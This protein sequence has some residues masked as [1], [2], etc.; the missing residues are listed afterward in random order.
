MD[1]KGI[2]FRSGKRCACRAAIGRRGRPSKD[3][4]VEVI[5]APFGRLTEMN[6]VVGCLLVHGLFIWRKW[7]V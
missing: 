7:P 5:V 6:W 4:C 3:V 2:L 1:T